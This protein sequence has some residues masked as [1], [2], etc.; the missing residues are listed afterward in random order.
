MDTDSHRW[1]GENLKHQ[2]LKGNRKEVVIR[3]ET[4]AFCG[5]EI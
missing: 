4:L 3:A 1:E 2:I 5:V